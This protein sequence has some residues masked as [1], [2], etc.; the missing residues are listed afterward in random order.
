VNR[1]F[2]WRIAVH[3]HHTVTGVYCAIDRVVD[4]Y[5]PQAIQ[6]SRYIA[7]RRTGSEMSQDHSPAEN[8]SGRVSSWT[9]DRQAITTCQLDNLC[10]V[11]RFID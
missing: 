11:R 6:Q 5:L 7:G 2:S 9:V 1:I 8:V 10:V 3:Y 4:L